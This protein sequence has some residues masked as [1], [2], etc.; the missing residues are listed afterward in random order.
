[1][2]GRA[3][4]AWLK[5]VILRAA[6]RLHRLRREGR[7]CSTSYRATLALLCCYIHELDQLEAAQQRT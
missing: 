1:M 7:R 2:K 6:G 5:S 3:Y 4:L